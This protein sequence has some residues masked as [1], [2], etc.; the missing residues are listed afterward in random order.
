MFTDVLL[1]IGL[2]AWGQRQLAEVMGGFIYANHN[3]LA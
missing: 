1:V 2:W 3:E